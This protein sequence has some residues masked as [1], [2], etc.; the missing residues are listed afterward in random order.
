MRPRSLTRSLLLHLHRATDDV[1]TP[2]FT[3][4]TQFS[5]CCSRLVLS[6]AL[7]VSLVTERVLDI[8]RG[9]CSLSQDVMC[10]A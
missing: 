8:L 4:A 5:L 2:A 10:V 6:D 3:R 9:A 1:E 7:R